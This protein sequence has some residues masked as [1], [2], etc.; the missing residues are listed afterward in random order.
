MYA[1]DLVFKGMLF[2]FDGGY[3]DY[4]Y[5]SRLKNTFRFCE[6]ITIILHP[7]L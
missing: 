3:K 6:L 4:S 7:T 2:I 5:F 1:L